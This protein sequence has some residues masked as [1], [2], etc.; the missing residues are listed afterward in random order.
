MKL[1]LMLCWLVGGASFLLD[2]PPKARRATSLY[3]QGSDKSWNPLK[4]FSDM[5]SNFDDVVDDFL[6]KRMGNGEVF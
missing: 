4:D 5:M 1:A 3:N 2:S 6:Y